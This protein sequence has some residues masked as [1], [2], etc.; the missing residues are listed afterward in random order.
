MKKVQVS[1]LAA[2]LSNAA[3]APL[4]SAPA[5]DTPPARAKTPKRSTVPLFLRLD[6]E[7]FAKYDAEAV[8]RTKETGRGV[9]A[10]QIIIERLEGGPL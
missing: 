10:Q 1:D 3:A 7:L 5:G 6:P 4:V 8:R 2:R 9:S